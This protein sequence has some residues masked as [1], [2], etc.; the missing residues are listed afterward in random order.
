MRPHAIVHR[1]YRHDI[2]VGSKQH[3]GCEI[4][5][6]SRCHLGKNVCSSRGHD[7]KIGL[8]GEPDVSHLRF[9]G[10]RE[11]IA[12]NPVFTDRRYRERGDKP[13]GRIGH[14]AT[15]VDTLFLEPAN[16]VKALIGCDSARNNK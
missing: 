10:Q 11:K 3:R 15:D 1:G 12:V 6:N 8:S 16:Q 7:D 2:L 14:D 4:I 5:T 13:G 9:I